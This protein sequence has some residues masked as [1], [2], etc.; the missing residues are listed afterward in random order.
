MK[1]KFEDGPDVELKV[2]F[3]EE[4]TGLHQPQVKA[5]LTTD[6]EDEKAILALLSWPLR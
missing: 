5:I 4:M 6:T 1:I 3:E 2:R